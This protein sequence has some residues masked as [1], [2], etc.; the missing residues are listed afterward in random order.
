MIAMPCYT[1][2]KD[3]TWDGIQA[4]CGPDVQGIDQALTRTFAMRRVDSRRIA[5]SGFS[6]GASYALGPG[7]SNGDRLERCSLSRRG[8]SRQAAIAAECLAYSFRMAKTTR[9]SRPRVAAGAWSQ[10]SSKPAI[11]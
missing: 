1:S 8:S 11:S 4:S 2:F 5:I 10:S 3:G 7:L 6:D 9:F